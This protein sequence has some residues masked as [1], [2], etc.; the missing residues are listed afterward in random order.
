MMIMDKALFIKHINMLTG[1]I[2]NE[3]NDKK[4]SA[5]IYVAIKCL[6]DCTMTN[7]F[8]LETDEESTQARSDLRKLLLRQL[9]D[10]D[11][12]VRHIA[13]EGFC[14]LLMCERVNNPQDYISR[15]ILLKFDRPTKDIE[16]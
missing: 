10:M 11:F 9:R 5:M 4:K 1:F 6:F 7:G 3:Q 13:T 8:M 12:N 2:Q 14:K 16:E 15:L